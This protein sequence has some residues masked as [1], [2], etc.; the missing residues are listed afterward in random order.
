MAV[1]EKQRGNTAHPAVN[2]PT[3]LSTWYS[4]ISV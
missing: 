1:Q 4:V 2:P 3:Q